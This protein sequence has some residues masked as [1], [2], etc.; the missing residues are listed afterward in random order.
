MLFSRSSF[1]W[2]QSCWNSEPLTKFGIISWL[3]TVVS[4][5]VLSKLC[6]R[7]SLVKKDSFFTDMVSIWLC[8]KTIQYNNKKL[9]IHRHLYG[10]LLQAGFTVSI[11]W[12]WDVQLHFCIIIYS[13]GVNHYNTHLKNSNLKEMTILRCLKSH[14]CSV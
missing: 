10:P 14:Y 6:D 13:F 11:N 5:N 7:E 3:L 2:W 8:D 9:A 12:I 4:G 1:S